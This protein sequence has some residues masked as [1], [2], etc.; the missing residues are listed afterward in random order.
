MA[1][2][3]PKHPNGSGY[4]PAHSGVTERQSRKENIKRSTRG[5]ASRKRMRDAWKAYA[6]SKNIPGQA[7]WRGRRGPNPH[8]NVAGGK[9]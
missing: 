5:R 6:G 3:H 1:L 2:R 8:A 9:H 7:P 4:K